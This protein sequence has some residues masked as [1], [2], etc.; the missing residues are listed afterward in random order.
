MKTRGMLM[1][2]PLFRLRRSQKRAV[3]L[4]KLDELDPS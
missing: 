3:V 2:I 1:Y 4:V